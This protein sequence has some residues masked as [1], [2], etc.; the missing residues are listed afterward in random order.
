MDIIKLQNDTLY[1]IRHYQNVFITTFNK[2]IN[3]KTGEIFIPSIE[4]NYY[5]FTNNNYKIVLYQCNENWYIFNNNCIIYENTNLLELLNNY[6]LI[7]NRLAVCIYFDNNM[8]FEM[9]D[10]NNRINKIDLNI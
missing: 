2:I 5:I 7:T 4:N 1:N 8:D 6:L 3:D 10:L 9:D